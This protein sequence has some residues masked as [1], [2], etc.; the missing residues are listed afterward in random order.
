LDGTEVR[1]LQRF[2]HHFLIARQLNDDAHD[3]EDDLAQGRLTAV[4]DLL[5]T[6]YSGDPRHI[7]LKTERAQL[8]QWFWE[9]TIA[10]VS[11]LIQRHSGEARTALAHC[12]A[13]HDYGQLES[14]L[15]VLEGSVEQAL[16]G[17]RQAQQF[18]STYADNQ[19]DARRG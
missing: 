11:L 19:D 16:E 5:L 9:R 2:F 8:R 17:R 15:G 13:L 3:W 14:W 4:V 12:R 1:Q 18:L 7:N 10:E 6:G